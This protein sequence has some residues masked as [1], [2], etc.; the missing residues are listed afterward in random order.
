MQLILIK[1]TFQLDNVIA[2]RIGFGVA[3]L[4]A[5]PHADRS[6]M[7]YWDVNQ[8]GNYQMI[9]MNSTSVDLRQIIGEDYRRMQF[10]KILMHD[11]ETFKTYETKTDMSSQPDSQPRTRSLSTIMEEDSQISRQVTDEEILAVFGKFDDAEREDLA[12]AVFWLINHNVTECLD[13]NLD[14]S[15][16]IDPYVQHTQLG[17]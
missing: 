14:I 7:V 5:V 11:D 8:P 15:D 4:P 16:N 6:L 2:V 10:M 17:S 1:H 3:T 9:D 12:E 13:A